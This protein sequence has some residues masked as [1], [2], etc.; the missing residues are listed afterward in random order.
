MKTAFLS[1]TL[2]GFLIACDT[3][4]NVTPQ[5]NNEVKVAYQ[6][7]VR[8][9]G[10]SLDMKVTDVS[11]SRC[12]TNARCI[13]AGSVTVNLEATNEGK[14]ETIQ[15]DL[16]AYPDK[17]AQKIVSVGGQSYQITLTEVLPYPEAG[18]PIRLE[19]YTVEFSVEK[20]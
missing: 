20:K 10:T 13:T 11:D 15:I 18:K 19:D 3:Q 4:E 16:P 17:P 2:L 6:K 7:S 8:M 9:A 14:T 5:A 12:P 1:I